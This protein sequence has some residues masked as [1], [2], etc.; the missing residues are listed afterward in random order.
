MMVCSW[1]WKWVLCDCWPGDC[2]YAWWVVAVISCLP[3]EAEVRAVSLVHLLMKVPRHLRPWLWLCFLC[4][5]SFLGGSRHVHQMLGTVSCLTKGALCCVIV[6]WAGSQNV[7]GLRSYPQS[8]Q[9]P[10]LVF[11]QYLPTVA[12]SSSSLSLSPL[13]SLSIQ[14]FRFMHTLWAGYLFHSS[15]VNFVFQ[16][17]FLVYFL[18]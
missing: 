4:V 8:R 16:L 7:F 14:S 13:S 5:C 1:L 2:I 12:F 11:A 9:Q 3:W 15:L 17:D 6:A 18:S 10:H